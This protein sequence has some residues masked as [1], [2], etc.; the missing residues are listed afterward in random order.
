MDAE[1]ECLVPFPFPCCSCRLRIIRTEIRV[2]ELGDT[3]L[4]PLSLSLTINNTHSEALT[5]WGVSVRLRSL[6]STRNRY[7]VIHIL[8][9]IFARAR[10]DERGYT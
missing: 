3:T 10:H 4:V 1:V 8:H 7:M 6:H 5:D 9:T 2:F